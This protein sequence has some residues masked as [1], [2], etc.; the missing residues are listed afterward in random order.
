[1][2][3]MSGKLL[4]RA[5]EDL[6][7]ELKHYCIDKGLTLN[8]LVIDA[9]KEKIQNKQQLP[10]NKALP[11]SLG[12]IPDKKNEPCFKLV[13]ISSIKAKSI[14]QKNNAVIQELQKSIVAMGLLKPLIVCQ[15]GVDK[16][17]LLSDV[18]VFETVKKARESDPV[19]CEMVNCFVV[20]KKQI[21]AAKRQL[22]L[23]KQVSQLVEVESII[24]Q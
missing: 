10:E 24:K 15:I 14:V 8:Q 13:D 11:L 7:K 22:K 6:H 4:I 20:Q 3:I 17:D 19:K 18:T 12:K 5:D 21:D 9:V 1:M 16:Y 23:L 2:R